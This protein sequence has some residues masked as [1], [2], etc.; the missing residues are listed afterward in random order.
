MLWGGRVLRG[1]AE[2]TTA[3]V[4]ELTRLLFAASDLHTVILPVRDGLSVSLKL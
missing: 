4:L 3:G 1:P 2:P